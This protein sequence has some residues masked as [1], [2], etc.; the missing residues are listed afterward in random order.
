MGLRRG[1]S[2][3]LNGA[4]L[5]LALLPGCIRTTAI[6]PTEVMKLIGPEENRTYASSN[7]LRRKVQRLDGSVETVGS[8]FCLRV[9]RPDGK[10]V[11]IKYPFFA[12]LHDDMLTVYG[13]LESPVKIDKSQFAAVNDLNVEVIQGD[14]SR[15]ALLAHTLILVF[16]TGLVSE[17]LPF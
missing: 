3:M 14:S 6:K 9:T 4:L 1:A 15:T 7:P 10:A 16:A 2:H 8:V 17:Y 11:T 12:E 5:V 13:V